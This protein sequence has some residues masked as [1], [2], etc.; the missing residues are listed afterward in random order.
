VRRNAFIIL[1]LVALSGR[2][3]AQ[4]AKPISTLDLGDLGGGLSHASAINDR[5]QVVGYSSTPAFETHAFVWTAGEGMRDLGTL[6]GSYSVATDIN[7]RGQV[8][9]YSTAAL[10]SEE[11]HAFIWMPEHGMIDLGLGQAFHINNRGE[12]TGVETSAQRALLWTSS[13]ARIVLAEPFSF[14]AAANDFGVV[15]GTLM[16]QAYL[17]TPAAGGY[18]AAT[19]PVTWQ[20]APLAM[21]NRGVVAGFLYNSYAAIWSEAAGV[22]TLA[23]LARVEGQ[24]ASINDLGQAVGLSD[25]VEPGSRAVLWRGTADPVDLGA[26]GT[27]QSWFQSWATDINNFGQIAGGSQTD[28]GGW[29]ATLWQIVLTP[30]EWIDAVGAQVRTMY[31]ID[32][33]NR[34]EYRWLQARLAMADG[35]L[36]SG[37]L[38]AA[39][40]DLR[41]VA[42]RVDLLTRKGILSSDSSALVRAALER[43]A[44]A[45]ALP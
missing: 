16:G 32:A 39:Q 15:V 22:Q 8:V 42:R 20:F 12:A 45:L 14:A 38:G 24:A 3:A 43:A 36:S 27:T 11:Y 6:G 37:D 31:A 41:Q 18:S 30:R 17:W 33:L 4:G 23:A 19:L 29:H 25:R 40:R 10:D 35:G 9:G 26:L 44:A 5:G 21:N 28:S 13:G 34:S 2:V 1:L 7:D